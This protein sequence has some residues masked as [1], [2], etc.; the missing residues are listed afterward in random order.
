MAESLWLQGD[1]HPDL[2]LSWVASDV[3]SDGST[4]FEILTYTGTCTET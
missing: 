4:T 2:L 1:G 3:A